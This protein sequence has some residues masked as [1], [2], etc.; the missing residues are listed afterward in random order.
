MKKVL[1]FTLGTGLAIVA[2]PSFGLDEYLDYVGG[3]VT[4]TYT[5]PSN[6][7][8]SI[9]DIQTQ[10]PAPVFYPYS[11]S[12]FLNPDFN[13][14]Y[15]L[16][17]SYHF[18]DT[19]TRFYAE[20]DYFSDSRSRQAYN[21]ANI[22]GPAPTL[23]LPATVINTNVAANALEVAHEWRFGL[24]RFIPFGE[25]FSTDLSAFFEYDKVS[26]VLN[27]WNYVTNAT[28]ATTFNIYQEM[29]SNFRGWGPGIGIGFR[30]VPLPY[31]ANFSHFGIFASLATTLFYADNLYNARINI[32]AAAPAA[33]TPADTFFLWDPENSKSLV[34]KF[35][36]NFGIDYKRTY[37][38]NGCLVNTGAT[39]G[40]RYMNIV[41]AFKMGNTIGQSFNIAGSSQFTTTQNFVNFPIFGV[42]TDWGRVG[43]YLRF[44][45][46]GADS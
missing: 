28:G 7:G 31:C 11:R 38:V 4:A 34:G 26:Q 19:C 2:T 27:G 20:Y 42:P 3:Y 33:G 1:A 12:L 14:D 9:G 15:A 45:L 21:V 39:L 22:I 46:G 35:D 36:V 41:N 5:K 40:V 29:N 30:G 24:R 16:G 44:S 32:A 25:Y 13:W 23:T 10:T 6:N 43:P 37:R 18:P 17:I 8:L